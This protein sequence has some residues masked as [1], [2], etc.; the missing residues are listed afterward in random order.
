MAAEAVVHSVL[1]FRGHFVDKNTAVD[2][3]SEVMNT[4][5]LT[6]LV[7]GMEKKPPLA[8]R[9]DL[10]RKPEFSS[11][12]GGS[13]K[14]SCPLLELREACDTDLICRVGDLRFA[15]FLHH[16]EHYWQHE[17]DVRSSY[18]RFDDSGLIMPS[19][20]SVGLFV[21][22]ISEGAFPCLT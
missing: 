3:I 16:V 6:G 15:T 4:E 22:W 19:S 13:L 5:S 20:E 21:R 2:D 10:E 9:R 12:T 18:A 1:G 7:Q 17:D 14:V 8:R 11:G